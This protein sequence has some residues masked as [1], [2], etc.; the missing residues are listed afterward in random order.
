MKFLN[1]LIAAVFCLVSVSGKDVSSS[2]SRREHEEKKS[3]LRKLFDIPVASYESLRRTLRGRG[4]GGGG[5]GGGGRGG[6]SRGGGSRG[7]G[8]RGG[9]SR[10]GGSRGGGSRGGGKVSF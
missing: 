10:G 2:I 6:G 8:S 3:L 9:G 1:L 4:G 7:G 5:R